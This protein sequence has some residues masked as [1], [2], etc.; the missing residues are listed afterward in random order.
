MDRTPRPG[1][2]L[3]LF[4]TLASNWG[5]QAVDGGKIVWFELPVD[6]PVRPLQVSDGTFR[7]D[8][9]GITRSE[10]LGEG[11]V[12]PEV[13]VR[14]IGIPVMQLQKSS[15][16]YEALFRELR[17][18]KERSDSAPGAP[19]LPE[20]LAVLVSE[21]GT[22]F[23]GLG[24]GMDDMWQQAVDN[25][26]E[27]FDWILDLPRS[28]VA[29]CEFYDAMLDEADEF[30]LSQRLL[31]LPASPTSVAVRRWFLSE[32]IGQLQ[33]QGAGGLGR[34]PLSR[35]APGRAGPL[36]EAAPA[37]LCSAFC[38]AFFSAPWPSPCGTPS[39]STRG[40][41][42]TTLPPGRWRWK[43]ARARS[44]TPAP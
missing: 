19:A 21:I 26:I 20:R 8:L 40:P 32:L 36:T 12:S 33:R 42:S 43:P 17:L 28:A 25:K 38:S 6:Y 29:A 5:V 4:D 1:R 22:R 39:R 16:E 37:L 7:F 18:M 10:L 27:Y 31:T 34:Q 14:L 15:E 11:D 9:T 24:P 2:G 41:R 44:P 23:N 30:G 3:T 13:S 35:C